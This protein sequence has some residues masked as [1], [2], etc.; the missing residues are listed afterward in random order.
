MKLE[1]Y[2]VRFTHR[3]TGNDEFI[4]HETACA[5]YL[6]ETAYKNS[7]DG[8]WKF[9]FADGLADCKRGDNFNKATGRNIALDRALHNAGFDRETRKLIWKAYKKTGAKLE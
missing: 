3:E 1:N 9:A 5:I 8:Y 6:N 7:A 2:W 4:S